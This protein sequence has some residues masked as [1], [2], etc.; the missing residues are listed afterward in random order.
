MTSRAAKGEGSLGKL[1]TDDDL[2]RRLNET[3]N[4]MNQATLGMNRLVD[5]VQKNP[6]K[7]LNLKV[8]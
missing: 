1:M 7:Y 5:D 6:R 3:V 4:N 8:F 2:Y